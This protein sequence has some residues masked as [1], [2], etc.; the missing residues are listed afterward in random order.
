MFQL[1]SVIKGHVNQVR[2]V[3]PYK[4]GAFFSC[5]LD[6]TVKLWTPTIVDG[7]VKYEDAVTFIGHKGEVINVRYNP[8]TDT[9]ISCLKFLFLFNFISKKVQTKKLEI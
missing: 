7:H 4:D 6:N 1:S 8:K 5:S 9:L 3:D 2:G